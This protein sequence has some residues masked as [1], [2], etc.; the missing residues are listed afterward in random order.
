MSDHAPVSN[1]FTD[2]E[3]AQLQAEDFAAGKAVVILMLGIFCMG[4]V[5][6]ACVAYTVSAGIGFIS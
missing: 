4:V 5:L 3:W 1:P 2:A 6:Y